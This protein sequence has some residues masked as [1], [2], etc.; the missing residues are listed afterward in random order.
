M[1]KKAGIGTEAVILAGILVVA[2]EVLAEV[3]QQV[4]VR[5]V[6]GRSTLIEVNVWKTS[7]YLAGGL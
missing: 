3:T 6:D 1:R 5:L 7:R 4:E 2:L